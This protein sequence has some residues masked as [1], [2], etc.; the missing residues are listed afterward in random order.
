M[1]LTLRL[2]L[3]GIICL[4]AG[5][6]F[7]ALVS[8]TLRRI[9][10]SRKYRQ[11]DKYR[12]AYRSQLNILLQNNAVFTK[13]EDFIV[14]P[15]SSK[16]QAIEEVLFDF[17]N[18]NRYQDNVKVLFHRLGYVAFYENHLG[19]RDIITRASAIDK[20]GRMLSE[21]TVNKLV[22][23]FKTE[24]TE[25]IAVTVRALGK[26]KS[27][28]ALEGILIH[29]PMLFSKSLISQ[30]AI[31][32]ALTN[33]GVSAVPQLVEYG[34]KHSDPLILSS[35]LEVLGNN[36]VDNAACLFAIEHARHDDPEVRAKALKVLGNV[37]TSSVTLDQNVVL[38]LLEDSVWFVRLQAVRALGNL[39]NRKAIDF[40]GGLLLDQN[41]QV[42]D[43]AALA[44]TKFGDDSLDIF[45]K[46][47]KY[48]DLYAKESIC[49]EIEKTNFS[50]LLIKN[51]ASK[52]KDIYRKSREI[53]HTMH[54]LHFSTPLREHLT[55]NNDEV[56]DEIRLLLDEGSQT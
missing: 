2:I 12:K 50:A 22:Q 54:A 13:T 10:N 17:M 14:P 3:I 42:R 46:T 1:E 4:I 38:P 28:E 49:E 36:P 29:L 11:L 21:P 15:R 20:L 24:S 31:I 44:L 55:E 53:L 7:T 47:L 8:A 6:I 45:L 56:R 41:W 30:K 37:D 27:T 33:F 43:A 26:I 34:K 9:V 52:D 19:S 35:I 40:I 39:Y 51:L 16:F 5:L 25:I 23:M 32:T 18:V 48:N